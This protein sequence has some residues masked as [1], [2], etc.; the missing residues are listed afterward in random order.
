MQCRDDI[1]FL[2][3]I[4]R[5]VKLDAQ[6]ETYGKYMEEWQKER[7]LLERKV[8][9]MIVQARFVQCRC[10]DQVA[11]EQRRVSDQASELA[12]L[13]DF[14]GSSTTSPNAEVRRMFHFP[15]HS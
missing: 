1:V 9:F 8:G 13:R 11:E 2:T 3:P 12:S 15:L 5:Q 7:Q 10:R 6:R 14:R 4:L